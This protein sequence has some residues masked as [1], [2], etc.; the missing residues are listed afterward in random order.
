MTI[1]GECYDNLEGSSLLNASST[2]MKFTV[3]HADKEKITGDFLTTH[4]EMGRKKMPVN[5]HRMHIQ[6]DKSKSPV[7]FANKNNC[8]SHI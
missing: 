2:R 6:T 3:Q 4:K 8:V 1:L 7:I 5:C